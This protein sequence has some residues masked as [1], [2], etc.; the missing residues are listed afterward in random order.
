M[1]NIIN[2]IIRDIIRHIIDKSL[3]L[4]AKTALPQI[5][6]ASGM[7]VNQN[8]K[9]NT[10]RKKKEAEYQKRNWNATQMTTILIYTQLCT[11][12]VLMHGT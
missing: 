10:H 3:S 8:E 6:P 9:K 5:I 1:K 12:S 2:H 11:G 4:K 7:C